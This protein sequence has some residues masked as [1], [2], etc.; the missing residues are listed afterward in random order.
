MWCMK[1]TSESNGKRKGKGI[2]ERKKKKKGK[3]KGEEHLATVLPSRSTRK[4]KK[5]KETAKG[6]GK[7][8]ICQNRST[9]EVWSTEGRKE[10]GE[11][12]KK[13]KR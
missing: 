10:G 8:E 5:E 7:T 6:K 13:G 4:G 12:K 2:V 3:K 9:L 1:L 11:V